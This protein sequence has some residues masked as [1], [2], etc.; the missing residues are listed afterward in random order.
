M[1]R[2]VRCGVTRTSSYLGLELTRVVE[3]A[4]EKYGPGE[5]AVSKDPT[6]E[7][8]DLHHWYEWIKIKKETDDV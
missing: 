6:F 3:L 2:H 8:G 7:R 1:I 4:E 5:M